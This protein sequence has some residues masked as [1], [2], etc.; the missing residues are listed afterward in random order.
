MATYSKLH[1]PRA[2]N[3]TLELKASVVLE[4]VVSIG[5]HRKGAVIPIS[6][7][8]CA[9]VTWVTWVTFY[10]TYWRGYFTVDQSIN[11]RFIQAQR[12]CML[13]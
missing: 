9:P 2:P 7:Y 12:A 8:M 13:T 1:P 11:Q 3:S 5:E 6:I 4:K 10:A